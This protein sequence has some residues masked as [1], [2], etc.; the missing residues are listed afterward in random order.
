MNRK[1]IQVFLV[2]LISIFLLSC[3][4]NDSPSG[5]K[6]TFLGI[7]AEI[8]NGGSSLRSIS[9]GNEFSTGSSVGVFIEGDG[10]TPMEA[11]Y[12]NFN[13]YWSSCDTIHLQD[14]IATVYG[15]YPITE[16]TDSMLYISSSTTTKTIPVIV[17]NPQTFY[18]GNQADYMYALA[19]TNNKVP[20]VLAKVDEDNNVASLVFMHGM[21]ELT[22]SIKLSP[23]Y[24]GVVS[25]SGIVLRKPEDKCDFS[26][27]RGVMSLEAFP[28]TRF[29]S[30]TATNEL[31]FSGAKPL[32]TS[33]SEINLLTVPA[34]S[35]DIL[36]IMNLVVN[37]VSKSV[38]G[39][40]PSG[41]F[42]AW[43][44]GN[45]YKYTVTISK[46]ELTFGSVQINTW[47]DIDVGD[48]SVE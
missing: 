4:D 32:S 41:D 19:S 1:I 15:H 29:D 13:G 17:E 30:L 21:A 31:V 34:K 36:L 25:V 24:T 23:N 47:K 22:F 20:D 11:I 48:V 26:C 5:V 9:S 42:D 35:D 28:V 27:G 38:S 44:S 6:N 10:Y 40:L 16:P 3:S 46:G 7:D 14:G 18:A 37:G 43:E 2:S 33:E 12:A 8:V 39:L 45:N